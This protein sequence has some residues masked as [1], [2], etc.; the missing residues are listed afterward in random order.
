MKNHP[1]CV[2][3]FDPKTV[4]SLKQGMKGPNVLLMQEL[5]RKFDPAAVRDGDFGPNTTRR[6]MAFQTKKGLKPDGV[7][8]PVTIAALIVE[9]YLKPLLEIE[10]YQWA[11]TQLGVELAAIQAVDQVESSGS[12]FM[13]DGRPD[14]LFERHVMRQRML[15]NLVPVAE[16]AEWV[17]KAPTLVNPVRGGYSGGAAE[18]TR[19]EGAVRI[20]RLSAFESA[21]W[22]AY[23]IMGYHWKMLQYP[24]VETFV[25]EMYASERNHLDAFVRFIKADP[26]LVKAMQSRDWVSFARIYNGPTY[27]EGK[28]DTKLA[29]AYTTFRAQRVV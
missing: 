11:A 14:I 27:A 17:L 10:D 5:L 3:G 28:Y 8:G 29:F 26:R 2:P 24:D 12:G 22:G 15:K 21:S 1:W 6:V 23:Q 16:V 25:K 18:Y 20:H 19:L 9:P 7:V 13:S 4:G